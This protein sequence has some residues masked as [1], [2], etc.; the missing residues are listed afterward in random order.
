MIAIA[1]W[2]K[3]AAAGKSSTAWTK[4]LQMEV[5]VSLQSKVLGL[6]AL[7]LEVAKRRAE[8]SSAVETA[9]GTE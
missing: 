8:T 7:R 2:R 3:A 4:A 6:E 1:D 5:A 9:F